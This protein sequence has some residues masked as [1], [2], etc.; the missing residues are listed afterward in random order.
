MVPK[1]AG[2]LMLFSTGYGLV[3]VGIS[4]GNI[5]VNVYDSQQSTVS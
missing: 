5:G 3:R 2:S 4:G 1:P